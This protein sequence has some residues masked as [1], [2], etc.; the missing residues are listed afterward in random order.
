M[1]KPNSLSH[2]PQP[3]IEHDGFVLFLGRLDAVKGLRTLLDAWQ[4]IRGTPLKI[5][6]DGPL[7]AELEEKKREYGLSEVEFVGQ[8][9]FEICME[10]LR[11]ARFLVMPSIWF[12]MF[13]LTIREAFACGKAVLASKLGSMA[14]LVTDGKTG[15]LFNPGDSQDLAKKARWMLENE[16]KVIEMGKNARA[17]FEAKYTAERNYE[18]LMG[19]Y[20]KVMEL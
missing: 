6:G 1:V 13:P 14:E 8:L 10:W 19:I 4:G 9:P 15:L 18:I 7:R 2:P 11:H 17:E 16:E 12:E 20:Q 5:I 3:S